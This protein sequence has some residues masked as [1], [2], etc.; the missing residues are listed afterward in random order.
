MISAR[1]LGLA[2]TAAV[3]LG[4]DTMAGPA[5]AQTA[6]KDERV[7]AK[8]EIR[9]RGEA[10]ATNEAKQNWEKVAEERFG[11]SYGKW[12]NAK[13]P[14]IECESA[15]SPRVGLPAKVCTATGRPCAGGSNTA[16]IEDLEA[17]KL[18]DRGRDRRRWPD[19]REVP[20]SGD[21]RHDREMVFQNRLAAWRDRAETRAYEREMA[22]QRRLAKA[23]ERYR[24]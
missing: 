23:R 20:R 21:P 2:L 9:V 1:V 12:A 11:K 13:D 18:T 6:C 10:F 5:N 22:Y 15:K 14:N 16:V 19:E 24:H 8:S 17:N 4:V 7:R 3:L